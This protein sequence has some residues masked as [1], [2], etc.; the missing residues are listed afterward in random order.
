MQRCKRAESQ[1]TNTYY[2]GPSK[3][4]INKKE[5][6]ECY[7]RCRKAKRDKKFELG[8]SKVAADF[9]EAILVE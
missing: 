4:N 6:T 9:K 3:E 8:D 5:S 1:R 2:R 7:K